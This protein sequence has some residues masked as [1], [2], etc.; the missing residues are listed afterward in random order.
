[1]EDLLP[2]RRS[3]PLAGLPYCTAH[4]GGLLAM[5]RGAAIRTPV[6][7]RPALA[8]ERA[9]E[10]YTAWRANAFD[11]RFGTDTAV[12][13]GAGHGFPVNRDFLREML[14]ALPAH[15]EDYLFVDVA[16]GAGR[17]V[18]LAAE[19]PFQR[20]VGLDRSPENCDRARRNAER[21]GA[22]RRRILRVDVVQTAFTGWELPAVPTVFFLDGPLVG[23]EAQPAIEHVEASL[24][25]YPRRT[26]VVYRK[27]TE[28][29]AARLDGSSRLQLVRATP[30]WRIYRNHPTVNGVRL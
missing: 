19:L 17:A 20:V 26:F 9:L 4:L 23:P 25:R 24:A 13:L 15:P 12:D 6:L 8:L 7:R 28:A 1:M 18:L 16:A 29:L 11:R 10:R 3:V 27:P 21:F 5:A 14:R 2:R 30:F 22:A